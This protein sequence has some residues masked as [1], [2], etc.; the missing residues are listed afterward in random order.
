MVKYFFRLDDIAPNMNW[1]NFHDLAAI[2]KKYAIKPLLAVIPDNKDAELLKYFHNADFWDIISRLN[3][4]GWIIAQHGYRHFYQTK[5]GGILNINKKGEFSG[6]NFEVQRQMINDGKGIIKEKVCKP[7]IFVA[8]A[9]SLDKNTI[10]ALKINEFD[11]ISDG[12]ALYPFK[13]WDIVWLPQILWRPRKFPFGLIT[14]AFHPNTMTEKDFANLEK[15]IKKNK[16][17]IGDFSEL[18]EWYSRANI[19]EKILTFLIN[20][21]FK[22]IWRLIFILKHGIS[23]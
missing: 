3:Q 5:N 12:V 13:K 19:L 20:L 7:K 17:K 15:F 6:L 18:I 11:F 8:P 9:H 16:D 2:F 10:E 23:R 22:P 14:V 21:I 4:D 1:N